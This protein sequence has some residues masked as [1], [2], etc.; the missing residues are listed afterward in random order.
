MRNKNTL[1]SFFVIGVIIIS[2]GGHEKR[3]GTICSCEQL[4]EVSKFVS[5]NI[6]KANNMSDEEMEDVINELRYTA[7]RIHCSQKLMLFKSNEAY[8]PDWSIEKLDSCNTY[9]FLFTNK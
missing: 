2:C 5:E 1:F 7:I 8:Q 3:I 9:H 6:Q 4:K